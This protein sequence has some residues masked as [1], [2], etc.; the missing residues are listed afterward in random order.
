MKT[1]I[2]ML[3][4]PAMAL[5]YQP[6]SEQS[7]SPIDLRSSQLGD[8]RNQKDVSW[9]YAFSASDM[10]GHAHDTSER[11]SAADVAIGYNQ[12]AL[13]LF[14]RWMDVNVI[15][16]TD[17]VRRASAHQT[18]FNKVALDRAMKAGWCPESVFP[19]EAWTKKIRVGSRWREESVPLAEAMLDIAVLHRKRKDLTASNIPYYYSFK[20]VDA[21]T[22]VQLLQPKQLAKFYFGLRTT[23][24]RDD[25]VPFDNHPKVKMVIKNPKVLARISEQL[26]AGRLVG[27][28]YDS[29]IL[30]S[31]THRGFSIGEL[32]TSPIVGR[33]WNAERKSCE[34]LI[35][36][37]Y[38]TACSDRYDPN[39][40]CEEGHLWLDESEIFTSMTSIVYMLS[41]K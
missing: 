24:C 41:G 16:R 6:T 35:R 38:G 2:V 17:G 15:N 22:F 27:L 29:R 8:V 1:W 9:C 32:H 39:M 20:N 18:G 5:A 30:K 31:R 34:F 37:S 19:S 3:A 4:F 23:V 13:G 36:N 12:S 14:V 10:L 40:D 33:R 28:D 26:E 21:G 7:C 11:V 25:R